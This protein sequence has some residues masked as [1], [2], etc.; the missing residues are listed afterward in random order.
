MPRLPNQLDVVQ[1]G[2]ID[3]AVTI[4]GGAF[5]VQSGGSTGGGT[6]T[7]AGS[8]LL[9]LDASVSFGGLVAG[10]GAPDRLDLRDIAFG[11]VRTRASPRPPTAPAAR[12]RSPTAPTPPTSNCSAS[13]QRASSPRRAMAPAA[14]SLATRRP[15]SQQ[16]ARPGS[17]RRITADGKCKTGTSVAGPTDHSTGGKPTKQKCR[18]HNQGTHNIN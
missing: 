7:F 3:N 10:F 8:G 5:D 2:G 12:R 17:L 9:V 1:S 6:V 13:T 15:A 16:A 11:R 4:S 18:S 14:R